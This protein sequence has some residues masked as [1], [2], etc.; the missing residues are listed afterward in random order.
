MFYVIDSNTTPGKPLFKSL[1]HHLYQSSMQECFSNADIW[2]RKSDYSSDSL[3]KFSISSCS[4]ISSKS[5]SCDCERKPRTPRK[6]Q[7]APKVQFER[8][9]PDSLASW[10]EHLRIGKI[11]ENGNEDESIA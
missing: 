5:F 4:S 8:L 7:N 11:G 2:S 3:E 6:K 9:N 10:N 1:A